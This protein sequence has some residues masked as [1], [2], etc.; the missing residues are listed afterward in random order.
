MEGAEP[1][2]RLPRGAMAV[3]A[4]GL[5]A[6]L[7]AHLLTNT[8]LATGERI[9]WEASADLPDSAPDGLGDG[10]VRITGAGIDSTR[11]NNSGYRIF[12]IIGSLEIDPGSVQRRIDADCTTEVP[13]GVII[14]RTPGRRASFPQPSEDLAAQEVPEIVILRFNAKG[15]DT[16]GVELT[17]A[18]ESYTNTADALVEWSAYRQGRHTWEYVFKGGGDGGSLRA[19]FASMWRTTTTDPAATITCRVTEARGATATATTRGGLG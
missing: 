3:V 18:F 13:D 4:I 6:T 15:S 12:R 19:R 10:E 9:D 11:D 14:A 8:D 2:S 7:A 17:D 5:L 1:S 16:N